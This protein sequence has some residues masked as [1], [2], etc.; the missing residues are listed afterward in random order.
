M[1]SRRT[2]NLREAVRGALPL[3]PLALGLAACEEEGAGPTTPDPPAGGSR[4]ERVEMAA[5]PASGDTWLE[6]EELAF[7][8]WITSGEAV[9]V[10][11]EVFLRFEL[12]LATQPAAL[13]SWDGPYLDFRY[14]IRRGDHDADGIAVPAGELALSPGGSLR[15]GGAELDRSVPELPPDPDHRVFARYRPGER[16]TLDA[17]FERPGVELALDGAPGCAAVEE[18]TPIVEAALGGEPAR[19]ES[20]FLAGA[21]LGRCALLRPGGEAIFLSADLGGEGE[22]AYDLLLVYAEG[23]R[24]GPANWWTLGDFVNPLNGPSG[25]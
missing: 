11:G 16:V 9:E 4:I 6:G 24:R 18:I 17:T 23:Q 21:Q 10:F 12:G 7:A 25:P 2:R 5:R 19:A 14:R 22:A 1:K 3:F 13:V 20:L 15:V 8:V